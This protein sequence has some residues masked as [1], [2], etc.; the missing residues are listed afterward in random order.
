MSA[1]LCPGESTVK[2][3]EEPEVVELGS[4]VSTRVWAAP[5]K[6]KNEFIIGVCLFVLNS[7]GL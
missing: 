5:S 6:M 7:H 4:I 3:D 2:A 1:P